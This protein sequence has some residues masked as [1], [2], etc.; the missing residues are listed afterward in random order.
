LIAAAAIAALVV[1][2]AGYIGMLA[3]VYVNQRD[4]QYDRGGR[5]YDLAETRLQRAELVSIP[6]EN[7]TRLAAWFAPPADGLPVVLYFRGKTESFSREYARY[8]D[9]ESDGYGFLAFDYQGFGGTPGEV[10]EAHVLAD[11]LSA[12][13]WLQAKGYPIVLW[14]R[15][16]GSGPA[17]YVAGRREAR[18]L[19][20]E[21]PFISAVS[22]AA[23]TYPYVPVGLLMLDQYRVDQWIE[24]VDE[25]VF[26][27]HGLKDIDIPASDGE[28][29][30]KLA[31]APAGIWLDP[32]GNHD[33][34]WEHG[35]WEQGKVFFDTSMR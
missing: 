23:R 33:N 18:A 14:G 4:L 35:V 5:M 9:M 19:L 24:A 31:A 7:G 13:D 29:V 3:Y 32:E 28:A 26:I 16:L 10:S 12:F 20:L 8:E 34:L 1:A 2:A 22:V 11:S 25:P 30:Y 15:S 6:G 21:S 27:A 17:T